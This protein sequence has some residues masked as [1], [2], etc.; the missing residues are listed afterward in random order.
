MVTAARTT[1]ALCFVVAVLDG[2]D[3][4]AIGVAAPRLAAE[5][6]LTSAV[7]GI[8]LSAT[9]IGLVLGASAGG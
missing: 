1:I 3:T 2:F 9:N 6:G 4:Q 5:L 7:L 8:A